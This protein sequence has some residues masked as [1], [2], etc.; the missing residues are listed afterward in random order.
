MEASALHRHASRR[1]TST[2]L[3][4]P[5]HI[6]ALTL[7]ALAF[8]FIGAGYHYGDVSEPSTALGLLAGLLV[9][10]WARRFHAREESSGERGLR[11]VVV[12]VAFGLATEALHRAGY[13]SASRVGHAW[14]GP[15][16][17]V[18]CTLATLAVAAL[19]L[20][21]PKRSA[22]F[23]FG[24][25]LAGTSVLCSAALV[26]VL[27]YVF[28]RDVRVQPSREHFVEALT[29]AALGVVAITVAT[30]LGRDAFEPMAW[31]T[32]APWEPNPI[33]LDLAW[34]W[35]RV[36]LDTA[37]LIAAC[38]HAHNKR[39]AAVRLFVCVIALYAF[40]VLAP[41]AEHALQ[42][43]C[44]PALDRFAENDGLML[45]FAALLAPHIS[46][47][48]K[49]TASPANPAPHPPSQTATDA[50]SQSARA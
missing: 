50:A 17:I 33:A 25:M 47:R 39:G 9:G 48:F 30:E 26:F 36:A 13:L 19:A 5:F 49:P 37:I 27:A 20:F 3:A 32:N 43:S 44:I 42:R 40:G 31:S 8:C 2:T 15:A 12:C 7:A 46:A 28:A 21:A 16:A 4:L 11:I 41:W 29:Q 38:A 24:G 14:R 18:T 10:G 6:L 23:A 34:R 1:V 22:A 45:A 35:P